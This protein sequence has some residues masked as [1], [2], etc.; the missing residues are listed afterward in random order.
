MF[1]SHVLLLKRSESLLPPAF[2]QSRVGNARCLQ[3]DGAGNS[4]EVVSMNLHLKSGKFYMKFVLSRFTPD[5]QLLW[6]TVNFDLLG[7]APSALKLCEI[8]AFSFAF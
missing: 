2:T 8:T 1:I 7:F 3:C 6:G 4:V 5:S